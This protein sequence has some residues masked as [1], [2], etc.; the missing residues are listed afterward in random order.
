EAEERVDATVVQEAE[1]PHLIALIAVVTGAE[2]GHRRHP[3]H[4]DLLVGVAKVRDLEL[5]RLALDRRATVGGVEGGGSVEHVAPG[6]ILDAVRD[7]PEVEVVPRLLVRAEG[8]VEAADRVR[9]IGHL[10]DEVC[11]FLHVG[12]ADRGAAAEQPVERDDEAVET[13]VLIERIP[14]RV[15][16][17]GAI[18]TQCIGPWFAMPRRL[19]VVIGPF[20]GWNGLPLP[21]LK[22]LGFGSG[23]SSGF[24]RSQARLSKSANTWQAAHA[25]SPLLEDSFA[26]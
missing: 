19:C 8:I 10:Q 15:A 22:G 18:A 23:M 17:T 14:A 9:R 3:E 2:E 26:S 25:A 13:G 1:P 24:P 7:R 21:T 11:E 5:L 16:A 4:A 12:G 6:A 20:I